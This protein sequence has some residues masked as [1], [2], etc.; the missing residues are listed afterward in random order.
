M[1]CFSVYS[2]GIYVDIYLELPSFHWT[3]QWAFECCVKD[4]LLLTR[5]FYTSSIKTHISW[6]L[7]NIIACFWC[8]FSNAANLLI[9][10]ENDGGCRVNKIWKQHWRNRTKLA[11]I[12]ICSKALMY[13]FVPWKYQR[14]GSCCTFRDAVF[15]AWFPPD[16]STIIQSFLFLC[17]HPE[18]YLPRVF[19][20]VCLCVLI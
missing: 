19:D 9:L 5:D 13:V 10:V 4:F 6:P 7:L 12:S 1:F 20:S 3:G 14:V 8:S 17:E 18:T 11:K 15:L 16:H 2:H